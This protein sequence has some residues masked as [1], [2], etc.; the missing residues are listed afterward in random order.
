MKKITLSAIC[1]AFFLCAFTQIQMGLSVTPALPLSSDNVIV[2]AH[3][4][5]YDGCYKFDSTLT[6]NGNDILIHACYVYGWGLTETL[7][8]DTAYYSLGN[9]PDGTYHI[10]YQVHATLDEKDTFCASYSLVD[11]EAMTFTVGATSIAEPISDIVS[12][13]PVPASNLL[14]IQWKSPEGG[15]MDVQSLDG[16]CVLQDFPLTHDI[17][18]LPIAMWLPGF[19]YCCVPQ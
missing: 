15:L 8:R 11:T 17:T 6:I 7:K 3:V 5:L 14:N 9:L 4:A 1:C 12:L 19:I 18:Q 13:Y 16:R 2:N 10:L